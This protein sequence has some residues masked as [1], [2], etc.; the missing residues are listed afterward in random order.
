MLVEV[1]MPKMGESIQEGKILRWTKKVGE[2]IGKDETVLEIST[3]KVDSEI[4]SPVAGILAKIIVAEQE[5]VPVGTVI[6]MVETDASAK[7]DSSIAPPKTASTVPFEPPR[8]ASPAPALPTA[9][10]AAAA[11]SDRFF[12]PLVKSIAQKEG[13]ALSELAG[14]QGSGAG[15]RINKHDVLAYLEKRTSHPSS[16]PVVRG[17]FSMPK[18]D[19]KALEAKYPSPQYRVA[20]MD[21]IQQKMAEHMVRSVATSPH[22]AAID[23]VDVTRIVNYRAKH[24]EAFERREGF[25]LTYTPF[26]LHATVQALKEFPVVNT[27]VEGDKI[28]YKSF[29]NLGMAVAT[30]NGLLVPC[31]KNAEEKSFIGLARAVNDIALRSRNKKLTPDDIQGGTFSVTNYGVFGNIIGTP[32]IN[33][34]QVAILGTGAIKK[35]PMVVTDED[36]SD[37]VGIRSMVYFTLS[38]DHRIIDGAIGGQFLARIKQL[39][40]NFDFKA[41]SA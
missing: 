20:A 29:I 33:Q 23:E 24:T 37:M 27:S 11:Q 3:D 8:Q 19:L 41:V 31:I 13:I 30:P 34:P 40:E 6:A 35:R 9:S 2:K 39:L 16:A 26:F 28:V 36:G 18:A 14:I 22:V 17:D 10:H 5:T 32:I 15:G 12:S 21:T 4:P 1:V 38:F 25:K 7:I